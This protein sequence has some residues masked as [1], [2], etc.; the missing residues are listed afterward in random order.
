MKRVLFLCTGNYYRSRFA[1][2]LFNHLAAEKDLDWE[3]NSRGLALE[4]GVNNVGAMSKYAVEAL[5]QRGIVIL[6][7]ERFP[8]SVI[9]EDFQKYDLIIAVDE[10][11]HRPLME[12]RFLKWVDNIEYWLIHDIGETPP[13][14]ALGELEKKVRKLIEELVE[15]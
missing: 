11:E 5:K 1:E 10:S 7:E 13:D 9:E 14:E 2:K 4:R 3:A 15:N 12:E 6:P 8:Q